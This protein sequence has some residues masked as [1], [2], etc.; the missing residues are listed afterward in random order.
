MGNEMCVKQD[1]ALVE[2][3]YRIMCSAKSRGIEF[4]L[5]LQSL[6]NIMRAKKCYFT[7]QELTKRTKSIDRIDNTKGYVKGNV[8][9]CHV[10]FN[11]KKGNLTPKEIEQL[12]K[13]VVLK[14]NNSPRE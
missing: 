14:N 11:N 7:G 9:A 1:K 13:G 4:E 6:R 12:Y 2:Y 10:K 5:P 8:V 3:Y